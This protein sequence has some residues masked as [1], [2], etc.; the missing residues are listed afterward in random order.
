MQTSN[1][2]YRQQNIFGFISSI[3]LT[4]LMFG[5]PILCSTV[6]GEWPDFQLVWP[7]IFAAIM[8]LITWTPGEM[9]SYMPVMGPGS[10]YCGFIAGNVTNLRMPAT[11]GT[12]ESLGVK[13]QTEESHCIA[14]YACAGSIFTTTIC[15]MLGVA[16]SRML[17]PVLEMPALQPAFNYVV[18][19]LFG[20]VV[21]SFITKSKKEF[22]K[23]LI[24]LAVALFFWYGQSVIGVQYWMLIVV[25][26]GIVTYI[27]DYKKNKPEKLKAE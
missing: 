15:M 12:C 2:F 4:I 25:F 8:M 26:A 1:E 18:P 10:L 7:A 22:A 17:T 3:I 27:A 6:T 21:C 23:Y 16:F 11:I 5:F 9:I 19:A 13:P 24:P 20:S 14:I